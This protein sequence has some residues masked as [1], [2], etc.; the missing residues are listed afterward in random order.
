MFKAAL[1]FMIV[2]WMSCC[3]ST[4][5]MD[6]SQGLKKIQD[7]VQYEASSL[8]LFVSPIMPGAKMGIGLNWGNLYRAATGNLECKLTECK[9]VVAKPLIERYVNTVLIHCDEQLGNLNNDPRPDPCYKDRLK[10]LRIERREA[11][12]HELMVKYHVIEK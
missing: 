5:A 4:R 2:I 1:Y 6:I 8:E 10:W 12:V 3:T 7:T 11:L 9:V